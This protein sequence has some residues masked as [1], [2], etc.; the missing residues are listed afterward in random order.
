MAAFDPDDDGTEN[1]AQAAAL[2]DADP[3]DSWSTECYADQFL[4]ERSGV[5]LVVSFDR[6][7]AR[8]LV[9]DVRSAPYHLRFYAVATGRAPSSFAGWG[10]PLGEVAA[11]TEPAEVRSPA[12]G[13]PVRH[14]LVVFDQL[15]PDPACSAANS[16]RGTIGGVS[17]GP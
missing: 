2:A 12:C 1:D 11:G 10:E 6:P 5:G 9:I 17:V 3:A 4:G 14:V 13:E 7:T 16:H 15:G 8:P